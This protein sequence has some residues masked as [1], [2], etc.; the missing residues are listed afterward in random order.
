[1]ASV[2][3][4]F[5]AIKLSP[6]I[7]QRL[8]DVNVL[9]KQR[10]QGALI[11]WVP[12]DNI[13]LTLKFLGD[14]PTTNLDMLAK[15]LKAEA[16][17]YEP[18]EISVGELGAFPS[19]HRPHVIWLGV[20]APAELNTLQHGI[21]EETARLG[22]KPEDR[23][24]SPHLTLGRVSRNADTQDF[25]RIEAAINETKVGFLGAMRVETVQLFKSDLKPN[26]AVY[27]GLLEAP[28]KS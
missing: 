7:H 21:E 11:R 19:A 2:I 22:Y 12:V 20:Q 23:P 24:F 13:H 14:V 27:T 5:I 6:E 25:A 1:L 9:L 26:G 16:S 17:Q 3:R 8:N 4:A 18:F 15:I 10:L 28:F